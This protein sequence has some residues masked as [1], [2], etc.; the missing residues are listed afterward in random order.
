VFEEVA[1]ALLD[2]F[3]VGRPRPARRSRALR[4]RQDSGAS[5]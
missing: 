4:V 3:A 2:L 5:S 1:A